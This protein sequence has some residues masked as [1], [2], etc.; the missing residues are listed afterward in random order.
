MAARRPDWD[1]VAWAAEVER[2]GA[3][4]IFL[5]SIDR[6]GTARGYD[7]ELIG[8]VASA[9][10]I[11]VIACGGVGRFSALCPRGFGQGRRRS[12]RQISSTSPN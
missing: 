12:R 2:R 7:L 6:D 1:P 8:A 5:N 3:G 4:E 9:T 11:P 10:T